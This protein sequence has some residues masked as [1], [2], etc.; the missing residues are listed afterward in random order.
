M[1]RWLTLA[2]ALASAGL[3]WLAWRGIKHWLRNSIRVD[4]AGITDDRPALLYFY[5]DDCAPCRWQQSPIL[6][7]L[8][9]ALGESV[10]FQEYDAVAHA[11]LASRYRVLTVPTTVVVTPA[12][13]VVAVNYGVT[14]AAKLKRQIAEAQAA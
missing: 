3:L 4:M 14:Q 2:V 6:V 1:D 11:D 12:G 5:T 9:E 13:Q 10:R 8:R 7:S